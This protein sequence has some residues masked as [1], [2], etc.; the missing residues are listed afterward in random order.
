MKFLLFDSRFGSPIDA[1]RDFKAGS[2]F[3]MDAR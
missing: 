2:V 1:E 3:T